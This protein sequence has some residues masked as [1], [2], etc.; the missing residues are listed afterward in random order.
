M[1]ISIVEK[2]ISIIKIEFMGSLRLTLL[3]AVWDSVKLALFGLVWLD[4][5]SLRMSGALGYSEPG[6]LEL[7]DSKMD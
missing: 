5:R 4:S 6:D 2:R 7:G 3:M 1:I